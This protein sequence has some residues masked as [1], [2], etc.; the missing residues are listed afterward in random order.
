MLT[1]HSSR[2]WLR[3]GT[4]DKCVG[5]LLHSDRLQQTG[6]LLPHPRPHPPR[7]SL[8]LGQQTRPLKLGCG[9]LP[10]T[11]NHDVPRLLCPGQSRSGASAVGAGA[12]DRDKG[13]PSGGAL[14][15]GS[16]LVCQGGH[17]HN[18]GLE[19]DMSV[20]FAVCRCQHV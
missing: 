11:D 8:C 16:Q 20:C 15:Q 6:A 12:A 14:Q 1:R 19:T 13:D 5:T 3:A 7:H 18:S 2:H 9:L 10:A 17:A 4:S